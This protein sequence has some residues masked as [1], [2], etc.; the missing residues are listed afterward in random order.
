MIGMTRDEQE[1]WDERVSI[2][3]AEVNPAGLT[4]SQVDDLHTA[5][6]VVATKQILDQRQRN[7]EQRARTKQTGFTFTGSR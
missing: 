6:D 4:D 2:M 5:I 7:I 3:L 1:L